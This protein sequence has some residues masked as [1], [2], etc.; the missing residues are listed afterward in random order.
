MII[1]AWPQQLNMSK[2]SRCSSLIHKF[3]QVSSS[4]LNSFIAERVKEAKKLRKW[5]RISAMGS[6]R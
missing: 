5:R 2:C 4:T 6:S 3:V 1:L